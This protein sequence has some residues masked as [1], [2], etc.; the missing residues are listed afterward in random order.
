[1][2]FFF[3]L[4]LRLLSRWSFFSFHLLFPPHLSFLLLIL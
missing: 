2:R 3:L 4:L 1:V